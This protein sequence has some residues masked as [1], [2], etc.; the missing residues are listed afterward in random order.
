MPAPSALMQ[1]LYEGHHGDAETLARERGED[2]L[3]IFEAAALGRAARVEALL[4][5]NRGLARSFSPDGF[6]PLHLAAFFRHDRVGRLLVAAGADVNA[7][8]RNEM[9]VQPLHSAA[10]A[11]NREL[12]LAL[13][14]AGADVNARQRHGWTPLHAAAENGDVELVRRLLEAGAEATAKNDDGTTARD[15]AERR[16]HVQLASI[17]QSR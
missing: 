1:A 16:G 3:D 8:S 2:S 4:A 11:G 9:R 13:I 15:L 17:L 6:T 7:E 12:A 5:R 10:A 14:D